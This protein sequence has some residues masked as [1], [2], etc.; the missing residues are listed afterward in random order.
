MKLP[1]CQKVL[2]LFLRLN[3]SIIREELKNF[4]RKLRLDWFFRND[5]CQFNANPLKRKSKFNLRRKDAAL[6][7]FGQEDFI[8]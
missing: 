7:I 3:I 1:F 2:K 5:E 6:E 4:G 8:F